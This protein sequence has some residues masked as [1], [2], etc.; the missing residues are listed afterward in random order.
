[1]HF[2]H[3]HSS[4]EFY[5]IIAGFILHPLIHSHS[6]RHAAHRVSVSQSYLLRDFKIGDSR[7]L[8]KA[9]ADASSQ[10]TARILNL[11]SCRC[12]EFTVRLSQERE[13][14]LRLYTLSRTQLSPTMAEPCTRLRDE[15]RALNSDDD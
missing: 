6:S 4:I 7:F 13:T 3:C 14:Y 8:C 5:R 10:S 1:M 12:I 2:H 15:L 11:C 9:Q